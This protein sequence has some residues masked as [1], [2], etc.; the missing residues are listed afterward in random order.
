MTCE[1]HYYCDNGQDI[2]LTDS[3]SVLVM[4]LSNDVSLAIHVK[5]IVKKAA[6]IFFQ[7]KDIFFNRTSADFHHGSYKNRK[8]NTVT[9]TGV[10]HLR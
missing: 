2:T 4:S 1:Q 10:P 5:P 7:S 9:I 3:L 6:L 8:W